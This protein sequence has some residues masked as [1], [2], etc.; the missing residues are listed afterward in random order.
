M[1]QHTKQKRREK[2]QTQLGKKFTRIF[3]QRAVSIACAARTTGLW[4]D[5]TQDQCEWL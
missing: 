1:Q 5:N 3:F 4:L 2:F